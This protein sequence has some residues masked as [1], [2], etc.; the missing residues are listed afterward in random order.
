MLITAKNAFPHASEL[1]T[2]GIVTAY[3][4]QTLDFQEYR[5][6]DRLSLTCNWYREQWSRVIMK[7]L[8]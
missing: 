5:V 2:I 1:P 6:R 8:V 3:C 7:K 4:R